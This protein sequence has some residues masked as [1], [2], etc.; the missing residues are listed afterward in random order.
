[1]YDPAIIP[2]DPAFH[3]TFENK[4]VHQ[5]HVSQMWGVNELPWKEWQKIIA[6]YYGYITMID[7][8]IGRYIDYLKENGLYENSLIVFTADHGEAMGSNRLI[9]KG[10]F[11]YD[12]SYKIPMI[13]KQPGKIK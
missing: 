1:M 10:E 6:R 7:K 13:I 9:E 8:Y 4:P 2:V 3:E 12:T 5:K 11:M